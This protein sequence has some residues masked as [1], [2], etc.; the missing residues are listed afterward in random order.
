MLS[1]RSAQLIA[2]LNL[3]TL[4][5]ETA[6]SIRRHKFGSSVSTTALPILATEIEPD[7]V[8]DGMRTIQEMKEVATEPRELVSI[9]KGIPRLQLVPL[10]IVALLKTESPGLQ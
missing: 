8:L 10:T 5:S 1:A 2:H 4:Q 9:A 7:S 6:C 3:L